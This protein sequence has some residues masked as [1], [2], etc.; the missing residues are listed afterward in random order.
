MPMAETS[1]SRCVLSMPGMTGSE[2]MRH[3]RGLPGQRERPTPA[4]ALTA[5]HDPTAR[6]HALENGFQVYLTTPLDPMTVVVE[7]ERLYWESQER[8]MRR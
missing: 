8:R 3:V 4:I 2:F 1:D 6:R 7:I 5:F